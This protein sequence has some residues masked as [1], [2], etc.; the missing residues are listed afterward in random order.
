VAERVVDDLEAVQVEAEHGEA[1]AAPERFVQ[2]LAEQRSVGQAGQ[3]VVVRHVRDARLGAAALGDVLEGEDAAAIRHRP[4]QPRHHLP[5]ARLLEG[6]GGRAGHEAPALGVDLVERLAR[7]VAGR[8]ADREHLAEGHARP[9][10]PGRDADHLAQAGVHHREPLLAVV[11]REALGHVV[12]RG[13]EVQVGPPQLQGVLPEHLHRGRHGADLVAPPALRHLRRDVAARQARHGRGEAL[14][15]QDQAAQGHEHGRGRQGQRRRRRRGGEARPRGGGERLAVLHRLGDG[16]V[17]G[18]EG[19]GE[20]GDR[21]AAPVRQ[22]HRRRAA[23]AGER[24][25]VAVDRLRVLEEAVPGRGRG[26]GEARGLAHQEHLP[27]QAVPRVLH[28]PGEVHRLL[29]LAR[30]EGAAAHPPAQVAAAP[31]GGGA[32]L[33][34]QAA[35]RDQGADR[36]AGPRRLASACAT[37]VPTASSRA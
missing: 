2:P 20:R 34:R 18:G 5:A 3:R 31:A 25:Q 33:D 7:E 30:R 27:A 36:G 8:R 16:R 6:R 24:H 9:E 13:V 12:E 21:P 4:R 11:H 23:I 17:A 29:D 10:A 28:L 37:A 1:P 15:R 19:A 14:H 26:G 35:D 22:G 32:H